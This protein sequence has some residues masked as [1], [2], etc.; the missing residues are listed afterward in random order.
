[1]TEPIRGT[2]DELLVNMGP[3]HPSTHGVLR[4]AL[5]L[6]GEK[7]LG[8]DPDIGYLHSSM[9]KIAEFLE[10]KQYVSYAD[11][12][13]YLNAMGNEFCYV[14]AVERLAG[15]EVTRRCE[16]IRVIMAELNR[17]ASHLLYFGAIAIDTGATT[18]FLHVF[19]ERELILDLFEWV[20][21]QRLLYHYMRVGGVRNDL[22][23][24]WV[25]K[26]TAAVDVMSQRF[27]E[28]DDLLTRN[29]IF[30]G[31]TRKVGIIS[32]EKALRYGLTGPCLR[33]CGLPYDLRK[34]D[35]YSVYPEFT[36]DVCVE[37]GCD[38]L[39]RHLVRTRE[40]RESVKIIRQALEKLPEG[41]VNVATPRKLK[42]EGEVYERVESP[43]G[44]V[45]CYLV[46]DGSEK[47]WRLHW[48]GPSFYNLSVLDT[49]CTGQWM[50]DMVAIIASTDIVLA[51]VDR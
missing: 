48:R 37:E 27:E 49:M 34:L 3:Q 14:R 4:V 43:R 50:A 24:G 22:P 33:A 51:D 29:R 6:D 47:P 44:E 35:G 9:E 40:L 21:G 1:M 31:R 41:E 38:C 28:Y 19:R 18:A 16:Y 20:C 11:R 45:G 13:D 8:A 5:R 39:S 32:Q 17:L 36:F 30:V 26:C 25:E 10:Y 15:I 7:V 12:F 2:T 23:D 42:L 46:G